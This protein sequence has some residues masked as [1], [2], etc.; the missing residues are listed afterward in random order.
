MY[1]SSNGIPNMILTVSFRADAFEQPKS[2][3]ILVAIEMTFK[4]RSAR[5][6]LS[7]PVIK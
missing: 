4:L 5:M 7:Y 6:P 3:V 2:H 1:Y